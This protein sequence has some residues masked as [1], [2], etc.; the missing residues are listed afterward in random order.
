[1]SISKLMEKLGFITKRELVERLQ[2][3]DEALLIQAL[4]QMNEEHNQA[5]DRWP[6]LINL[7]NEAKISK[8]FV[9]NNLQYFTLCYLLN[10][11]VL[12]F[13][14]CKTAIPTHFKNISDEQLSQA[15]QWFK[16]RYHKIYMLT[17]FNHVSNSGQSKITLK[18]E[19]K[20]SWSDVSLLQVI[21]QRN[22]DLFYAPTDTVT[23][24]E[25]ND[26]KF[27][28]DGKTHTFNLDFTPSDFEQIEPLL[29]F[30]YKKMRENVQEI[31]E[32]AKQIA[33]ATQEEQQALLKS[34]ESKSGFSPVLAATLGFGGG[35]LLDE[36]I[37]D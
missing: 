16:L 14:D 26:G 12:T 11:E 15:P 7:L 5:G 22:S 25:V 6:Y 32:N 29:E 13:D 35:L 36:A 20:Y 4:E 2:S 23:F 10:N 28:F 3:V 33:N 21:I 1:M 8:E 30:I 18:L 17:E 24:F 34:I 9:K 19:Q 27:Y 31:K 37:G